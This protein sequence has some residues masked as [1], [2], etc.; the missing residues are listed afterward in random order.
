MNFPTPG[1]LP[2]PASDSTAHALPES[3]HNP[4]AAASLL[5]VD[6]PPSLDRFGLFGISISIVAFSHGAQKF[7]VHRLERLG[8]AQSRAG[9]DAR[10]KLSDNWDGERSGRQRKSLVPSRLAAGHFE[11]HA[12]QLVVAHST[13]LP[14]SSRG[15]LRQP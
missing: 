14:E 9:V 5:R 11:E 2:S 6:G 4:D 7:G 3:P 13:K 10:S 8:R 15:F 1:A 12:P